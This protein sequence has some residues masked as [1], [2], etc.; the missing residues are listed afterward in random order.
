MHDPHSSHYD[1]SCAII[2][3]YLGLSLSF[4]CNFKWETEHFNRHNDHSINCVFSSIHHF[5]SWSKYQSL[6][7]L[8]ILNGAHVAMITSR[9]AMRIFPTAKQK[10]R[11]SVDWN[12]CPHAAFESVSS[13]C[14]CGF[15]KGPKL[16][17]I[18]SVM[19]AEQFIA[20]ILLHYLKFVF[21]IDR[22]WEQRL[23]I[24]FTISYRNISCRAKYT[25]AYHQSM[26]IVHTQKHIST[27]MDWIWELEYW[28]LAL[29]SFSFPPLT[30]SVL[31]EKRRCNTNKTEIKQ[32][33]STY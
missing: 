1:S 15:E 12:N 28:M 4:S 25:H 6:M 9:F 20:T 8:N 14:K 11:S 21:W 17:H 13:K 27:R 10:S 2:E 29:I 5:W 30:E 19:L 3:I 33:Q 18:W 23:P 22:V 24:L 31:F 32:M 16:L 26:Y 7:R